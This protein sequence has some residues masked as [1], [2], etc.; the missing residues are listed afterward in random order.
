MCTLTHPDPERSCIRDLRGGSIG[1]GGGSLV[2]IPQVNYNIYGK[3]THC[4]IKVWLPLLI[5]KKYIASMLT[6]VTTV[7]LYNVTAIYIMPGS[8]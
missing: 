1:V 7:V 5:A 3:H 2:V 8:E 6:V 4:T